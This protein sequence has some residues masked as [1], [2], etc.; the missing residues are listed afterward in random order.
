MKRTLIIISV[1]VLISWLT[2]ASFAEIFSI[3]FFV[4][5]NTDKTLYHPGEL[6]NVTGTVQ[7]NGSLISELVALQVNDINDSMA[8]RTVFSWPSSGPPTIDGD[9]NGDGRVNI[10]DVVIVALHFGSHAGEPNYD[11]TADVNKDGVVNI[12]DMSVVAIHYGQG[13]QPS[14]WRI[15]VVD[16]YI[17]D[18][19]GNPV[20]SVQR[21]SD[22]YVHVRYKNTQQVPIQALIAFSIFDSTNVPIFASYLIHGTVDPGGPFSASVRWRVPIDATLGQAKVYGN[23]YSDF[24]QNNGYPHCPEKSSN[25]NIVVAG[26]SS[27]LGFSDADFQ[28]METPGYYYLNFRIP[29]I[30]TKIGTYTVYATSFHFTGHIALVTSNTTAFQV[31]P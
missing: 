29:T 5:L 9:I 17:G 28:T 13:T 22:Y 18:L 12:L 24:P 23:A 15:E 16:A 14:T 11:L 2:V 6:V 27:G 1:A 30:G 20:S 26:L 25:F 19:Y 4:T 21:G 3:D 7:F 10:L 8:F 31:Q